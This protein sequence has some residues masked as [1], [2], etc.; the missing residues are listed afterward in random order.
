MTNKSFR[1]ATVF[2]S[3]EGFRTLAANPARF[4]LAETIA[5]A[6][7][8]HKAHAV[9]L[10]AGYLWAESEA[11]VSDMATTLEVPFTRRGLALFAGIDHA[12]EV[13]K[14]QKDDAW[15]EV[16]KKN[17]LPFFVFATDGQGQQ[18]GCWRQRSTTNWDVHLVASEVTADSRIASLLDTRIALL[19]CGEIF[20]E[21]IRQA[22]VGTHPDLILDLG[23]AG[24][25]RGLQNIFPALAQGCSAWV[26]NAQ[27]MKG[28][29]PT[30]RCA[31]PDGEVHDRRDAD[32]YLGTR[33]EDQ[34]AGG[35]WAEVAFW[36]IV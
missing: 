10:P 3:A 12:A 28:A 14:E 8:E 32:L 35:L 16:I 20:G 17:R 33:A 15:E 4:E 7:S 13:Q 25:G 6:C 21:P 22:V 29:F 1:L 9:A 27:H 36:D 31:T 30:K 24:M 34:Y 11:A 19:A 5:E 23:H 18:F 2:V 26:L